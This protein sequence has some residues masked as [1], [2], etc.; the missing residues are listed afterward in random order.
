M[1]A[2]PYGDAKITGGYKLPAKHVIH[3]VGP[4]WHGG[5]KNETELLANCYKNSLQLAVENGVASIAFPNIST[6]VYRFPKTLAARIALREVNRFLE[7]NK[8]VERVV[9]AV[10]DDEN[11][12]IYNRLQ[13]EAQE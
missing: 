3:T 4:I 13:A 12:S 5:E 11:L 1:A 7:K 9:F 8:K 2:L 10:F 6:G